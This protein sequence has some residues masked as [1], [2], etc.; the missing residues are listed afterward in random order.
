MNKDYI[1]PLSILGAGVL[2]AGAVIYSAGTTA[3]T[4]N[5]GD[6]PAEVSSDLLKPTKDDVVLG[7]LNAPVTI[8]E[9]SD[10]Q[11]PFC[12][13]FYSKTVKQVKEDYIKT[14][15]VKM[16]YRHFAFQGP[17]SQASAQ[18]VECAKDQGKFWEYHDAIF[19]AEGKDGQ[20]NNGNLNRGLFMNIVNDLGMNSADFGSC[21]DGKK[22]ASKVEQDY[23]VGQVVGVD[24]VPAVFINGSRVSRDVN[25]YDYNQ[26]KLV[27]DQELAKR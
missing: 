18:A 26:F 5:E 23:A 10:F 25:V 9:Y 20:R 15:K 27:I 16:V 2:I 6:K 8:V 14:G 12:E 19:D 17:E 1:L 4:G 24:G 7:D 11:C 21:F 13:M 22:Y 3:P